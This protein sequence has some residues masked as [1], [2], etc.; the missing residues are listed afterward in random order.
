VLD[1]LLLKETRWVFIPSTLSN[2]ALTTLANALR[3][4]ELAV[5]QK[6]K[7]SLEAMVET[8]TYEASYKRRVQA[9]ATEAGEAFVVGGFRATRYA[10]AQLFV[11]HAEYAL[12]AG[13]IAMADASLQPHRGFPLLL[14]LAGLSAK[15]GLGIEAFQGVVESAYAQAG[16]SGLF[17]PGRI[18]ADVDP[19]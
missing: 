6:G 4:G 12:E 11:A 5:F 3:P 18:F 13:V 10:P 14:E 16:A 7:P 2:R 17:A 8:G 1:R 9:F 15:V 19:S